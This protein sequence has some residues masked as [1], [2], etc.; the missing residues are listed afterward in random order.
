MSRIRCWLMMVIGALISLVFLILLRVVFVGRL[1]ILFVIIM[2]RSRLMRI[3][4]SV[5]LV[6]L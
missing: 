6:T 5:L 4:M 1:V 3:R 2:M